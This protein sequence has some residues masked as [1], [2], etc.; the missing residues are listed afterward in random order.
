M[1]DLQKYEICRMRSQMDESTPPF[2]GESPKVDIDYAEL[3][4]SDSLLSL[5]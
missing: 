3:H 1:D 2:V 4:W 5:Q